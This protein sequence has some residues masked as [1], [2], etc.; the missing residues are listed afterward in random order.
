MGLAAGM[1]NS[2]SRMNNHLHEETPPRPFIPP[3]IPAEINPEKA[4]D[5]SEPVYMMLV[6]SANLSHQHFSL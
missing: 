1:L 3:S 2:P 6:L 5:K 4:P